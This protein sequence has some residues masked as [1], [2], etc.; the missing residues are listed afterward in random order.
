MKK[1]FFIILLSLIF[2]AGCVFY[3]PY[4]GEE[5]QP[6]EEEYVREEPRVVPAALDV[7]Y[8][9]DY[10]SPY[11]VWAYYPP[12]DY[13]WIPRGTWY[14]WRPYSNG[15]WVWTDY[16]WT[17]V[18]YFKWGWAPFHYGRWSWNR[19]IGWFWVPDTV[20]GPGW[21]TWRRSNL[22]IGWAPLP[23]EARFVVG[24][25]IR[26]LPFSLPPSYWVFVDGVYFLDTSL[27]RYIFPP[28]RNRTIIN[29]TVVQTN[30]YVRGN[31]VI[32]AGIDVD[33]VRR[34][35]RQ[36]VTKL[37]LKDARKEGESRIDYGSLEI[38]RP[39]IAESKAARP[40]TALN[41]EEAKTAISRGTLTRPEEGISP[42]AGGQNL[43]EVH[44]REIRL[45]QESQQKEI[46]ELEKKM[47]EEEGTVK[48][49]DEKMKIERGY[50]EKVTKL[51]KSHEEE[52][53]QIEQR[54]AEEKKK[55]EK[56]ESEEKKETEKKVIKKKKD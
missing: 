34:V 43:K 9:Y 24:I 23:P 33:Q 41:K 2:A 15:R 21:V 22:Y 49:T 13:V 39:S 53:S 27:N 45:L 32:N 7:S 44:S 25:G 40:K 14:G 4:I 11:G 48:N 47:E 35:T 50:R 28:E 55:A 31:R 29:Y 8:F 30:I 1:C 51:K 37:E 20:W 26:D 38:Y 12:Y 10:L 42:P 16:G 17:W 36:S 18:S 3:V 46:K 52:K 19:D 54:Q 6:P 56:K 5:G